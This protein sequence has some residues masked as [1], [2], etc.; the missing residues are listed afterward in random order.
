[1][2]NALVKEGR[3]LL[4]VPDVAGLLGC[5]PAHVRALIKAGELPGVDLALR[6]GWRRHRHLKVRREAVDDFLR[7]R[8]AL[9]APSAKVERRPQGKKRPPGWVQYYT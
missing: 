6:P 4:T 2:P 9:I 1:M 5:K 8:E 7:R 3:T